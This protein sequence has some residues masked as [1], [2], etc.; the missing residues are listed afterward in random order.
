MK[1]KPF[2]FPSPCKITAEIAEKIVKE[3]RQRRQEIKKLIYS[4]EIIEKGDLQ[5]RVQ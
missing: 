3:S 4:M 2:Q 1:Q 5:V